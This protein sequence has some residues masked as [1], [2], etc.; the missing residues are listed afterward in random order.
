MLQTLIFDRYNLTNTFVS[1]E[2]IGERQLVTGLDEKGNEISSWD[3]DALSGAGSI[4]SCTEDLVKFALEQFDSSNKEL[5][6][7][8]IPTFTISDN[9]KIALGW[10]IITSVKTGKEY[11]WHNGGTGGYSSCM[12]LELVT[13]NGVIILSNT[14]SADGEID[15]LCFGLLEKIKP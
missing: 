10:H 14:S 13:K 8:H 6:L 12:A 5:A 7:T 4:I 3:F 2:K 11:S 15:K 1:K 9:M